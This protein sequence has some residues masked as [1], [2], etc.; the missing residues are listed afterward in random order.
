MLSAVTVC[1][2]EPG[3]ESS[4]LFDFTLSIHRTGFGRPGPPITALTADDT[5]RLSYY[6][7]MSKRTATTQTVDAT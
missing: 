7:N 5:S 4:R 6:A 2:L 3:C 1:E